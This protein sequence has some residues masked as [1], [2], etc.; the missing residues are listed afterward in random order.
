[1]ECILRRISHYPYD[2]KT[3]KSVMALNY[4]CFADSE[5]ADLL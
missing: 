5:T 1:M 2:L 4:T 3:E